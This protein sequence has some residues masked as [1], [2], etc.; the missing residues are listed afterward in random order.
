MPERVLQEMRAGDKSQPAGLFGSDRRKIYRILRQSLCESCMISR[1][2]LARFRKAGSRRKVRW[3][4]EKHSIRSFECRCQ[5]VRIVEVRNRNL[6]SA[7]APSRRLFGIP[8]DRANWLA[9][10][11]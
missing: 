6:C 5:C 11:Q 4:H 10:G 9:L 8:N 3:D 2:N 1:E 7:V